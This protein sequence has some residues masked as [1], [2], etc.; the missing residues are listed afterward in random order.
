MINYLLGKKDQLFT[1]NS[2]SLLH[3][4]MQN[5]FAA[6]MESRVEVLS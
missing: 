2:S 5:S 1:L 6:L 4:D 3:E